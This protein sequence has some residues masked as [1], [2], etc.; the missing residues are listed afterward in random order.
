MQFLTIT[1]TAVTLT[2]C[3]SMTM[4]FCQEMLPVSVI[5]ALEATQLKSE[6]LSAKVVAL[7]DGP[8]CM[9]WQADK[10]VSPASTEKMITTLAALELLGPAYRW[11]TSYA[12]Q[13]KIVSGTLKGTL[14]IRGSGD[15]KYVVENL[16][17]DL[18]RLKSQGIYRIEGNIAI[19]RS[20]FAR[21]H[22]DPE[23]KD[24]W[25]RPYTAVADAALLNFQSVS[26]TLK[27]DVKRSVAE[28]FAQPAMSD[29]QVPQTIPLIAGQACVRWRQ[30]LQADVKNG[31]RPKIRGGLPGACEEKTFSY[32]FAD[33]NRYWE[34]VL[35]STAAQLSI[36]W[37]GKVIEA[38]TPENAIV[39]F[40]AWSEE[41]AQLVR[42]TN[43]FSNNVFAKHMML[44]L[45]A[46]AHPEKPADYETAR[47]LLGKWL[48]NRVGVKPSEVFIDNGSGLS[49]KSRV[50]AQA[51]TALIEYGWKSPRMP[52]W[53]T[54]FPIAGI[55]GTMKKRQAAA[56]SAYVKTGLLNGVKSAGGIIQAASGKRY[57]FFC[58]VEGARA[59]ESDQPIDALI[60]WVFTNG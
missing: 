14:Y 8:L 6:Q 38:K 40:D 39:L 5:K 49:R 35:R 45:A 18:A 30:A 56:G 43:K 17:R 46:E 19:D 52:D 53:V 32:L 34:S 20:R 47:R 33:S 26:L 36:L 51:M 54:S 58:V 10:S 41:L 50:T 13:G 28:V 25:D 60:E 2:L 7:D 57:G 23:F 15:P 27:P 1:R 16:W 48:D 4:G 59:T 22:Q 42:Q 37:R 9:S 24:D 44:T 3:F 11:K 29:L 55:D 31:L 12:Y 21:E